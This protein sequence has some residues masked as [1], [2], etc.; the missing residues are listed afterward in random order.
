M[1]VLEH[2]TAETVDRV[3]ARLHRVTA[4]SG[5]LIVSVPIETGP[6]L[7]AKQAGRALAGLRGVEGYRERERYSGGE[8]LR[9]LFAG[10][11]TAIARP[12][13]HG[14]FADGTPNPYHGHKGFN[15]RGLRERLRR[16]F[17]IEAVRFSPLGWLPAAVNSQAWFVC[18]PR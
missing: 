10:P 11:A 12:L 18:V 7:I 13:Y 17:E 1:E 15:W 3:I 4:P 9:A 16:D 14:W 8:L 5:R 6:A 2:C